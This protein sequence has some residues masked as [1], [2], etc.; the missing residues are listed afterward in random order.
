MH[1]LAC[2]NIPALPLQFLLKKHPDWRLFPTV[3]SSKTSHAIILWANKRA[4]LL[5]VSSGQRYTAA[6][7]LSQTLRA[8]T[9][10]KA[11]LQ[12]ELSSITKTLLKFTP[13]IE[14]A[15]QKFNAL[16]LF[17]LNASGLK[18]VFPT[19]KFW[20]QN[21][22]DSLNDNGYFCSIAVGFTRFGTYAAVKS[23]HGVQIFKN[24][25]SEKISN[26]PEFF[27]ALRAAFSILL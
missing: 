16:G 11:I 26:T 21:I 2:I 18:N 1:Q 13:E 19:L 15:N 10:S 9:V 4:R 20:V 14:P 12:K 7:A 5:G 24:P 6:L 25:E 8:D 17:W 27:A 23:R 3:I 22:R